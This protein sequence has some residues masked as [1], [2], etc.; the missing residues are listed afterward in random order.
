MLIKGVLKAQVKDVRE[1]CFGR[2]RGTEMAD[3]HGECILRFSA[4][5]EGEAVPE[6]K[7]LLSKNTRT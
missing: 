4:K 7:G 5:T 2:G 1:V 3:R 6:C